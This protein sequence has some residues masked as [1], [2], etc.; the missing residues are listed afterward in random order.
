MRDCIEQVGAPNELYHAP[1][2]R[3]VAGFIGSPAMNLVPCAIGGDCRRRCA[4]ASTARSPF[5]CLPG[6]RLAT[7]R[8]WGGSELLFGLRPEHILERRPQLEPNQEVF[9]VGLEVTEPMGMETLVYFGDQRRGGVRARQPERRRAGRPAHEAGRR[10]RSHAPDRR[11]ERQGAV[12]PTSGRSSALPSNSRPSLPTDFR[13]S[14]RFRLAR[15]A[16][17]DLLAVFRGAAS[18]TIATTR[19]SRPPSVMNAWCN[20]FVT[21]TRSVCGTSPRYQP[22]ISD[23]HASPKLMDICCSVLAIVLAMLESESSMSA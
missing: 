1:A 10:P 17:A 15:V 18:R 7:A 4:Y 6:A 16:L 9:E 3:F 14:G 2:T 13:T 20:A 19:W 23:P 22:P 5:R 12:A 21:A 11:R 8:T